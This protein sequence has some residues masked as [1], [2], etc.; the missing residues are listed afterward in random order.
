MGAALSQQEGDT[1]CIIAYASRS[2]SK[3]EGNY[4]ATELECLAVKWGIWKMRD[5]LEDYHIVVL[6]DHLSL[7]W[8]DRIDNPSDRLA[9]WALELSQWDFE[10]K[11]RRGTDNS[12]AD[13][14]SRQQ[15][16]TC[17]IGRSDWY[18]CRLRS[19]REDPSSN[20]EF[21]IQNNRLYRHIL[22]ALDFNDY[23][24]GEEWKT[25]VPQA[26]QKR[27]LKETHDDPTAG[28]L[29]VAKTLNRLSRYYYWP[30]MLRTAT[31]YLRNCPK[32]QV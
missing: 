21:C 12:L 32:C 2:L 17:P 29:G 16:Q 22:H 6:T 15:L 13:T 19:V 31:R 10:I 1:E 5:Y 8:L 3:A 14:L 30:G 24:S 20:P 28:H 26:E 9:R 11:Y 7:K 18:Q 27:V 23:K 25:C 4:S